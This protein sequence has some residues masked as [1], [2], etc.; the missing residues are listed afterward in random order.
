M[1]L[2]V[3]AGC[4]RVPLLEIPV[5]GGS[6]AERAV[7]TQAVADFAATVGEDRVALSQIRLVSADALDRIHLQGDWSD[8]VVGGQ[9]DPVTDRVWVATDVQTGDG[10]LE[11]TVWHELCHALVAQDDLDTAAAPVEELRGRLFD[12]T[13][14]FSI[15]SACPR[16][17]L[18]RI[19]G[20]EA[21]AQA[22]AL[23]PYW[24]AASAWTECG[25]GEPA[26]AELA[27]WMLDHV[28]TGLEPRFVD[29]EPGFTLTLAV[30]FDVT[31]VRPS[32]SPR[33]LQILGVPGARDDLAVELY[34]GR[35]SSRIRAAARASST[36]GP[37]PGWSRARARSRAGPT[38]PRRG[39]AGGASSRP[40]APCGAVGRRPSAR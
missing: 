37:A 7:V 31:E 5:V 13:H 11:A 40:T 32:R 12:P 1:M 19:Q 9:Y 20:S 25:G 39:S 21:V 6:G 29:E 18:P 17:Y 4:T 16:C 24:A 8:V 35:S 30:D 26:D 10:A 23:G 3:M 33:V 15:E 14:P 28:W 38:A 22:C 27:G 34:T 36:C 2:L